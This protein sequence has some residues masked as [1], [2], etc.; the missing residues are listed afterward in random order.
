[1][2]AGKVPVRDIL[3]ASKGMLQKQTRRFT[4]SSRSSSRTGS[5]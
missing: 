1:M 3:Q 4:Q 5:L 2:S